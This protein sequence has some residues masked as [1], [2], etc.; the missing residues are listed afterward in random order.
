M[1]EG[2]RK[3]GGEE[4]CFIKI[5]SRAVY[6]SCLIEGNLI[7]PPVR[8]RPRYRRLLLLLEPRS[9]F[10]ISGRLRRQRFERRR[11]RKRKKEREREK[12]IRTATCLIEPYGSL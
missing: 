7:L 8:L 10:S 9:G 12:L 11:E 1:A 4:A 6:A 3:G 2:R 5:P